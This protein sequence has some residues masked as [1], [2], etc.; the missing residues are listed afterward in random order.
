MSK[1]KLNNFAFYPKLKSVEDLHKYEKKRCAL[2]FPF[3]LTRTF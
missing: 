2:V 1:Y 3:Y